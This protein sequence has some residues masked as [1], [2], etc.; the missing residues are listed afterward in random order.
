MNRRFF[1]KVIGALSVGLIVPKKL[2]GPIDELQIVRLP[3][4]D[5]V[6]DQYK[7]SKGSQSVSCCIHE[8]QDL[9]DCHGLCAT[10][11]LFELIVDRLEYK[12]CFNRGPKLV[13][14]TTPDRIKLY[15][16]LRKARGPHF[17]SHHNYKMSTI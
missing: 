11:S 10:D 17:C 6:V 15:K 13:E 7:I 8:H 5:F 14:L 2:S 1:L 4:H 16:F 3:N 12:D 9:V